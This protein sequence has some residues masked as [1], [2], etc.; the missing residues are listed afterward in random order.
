MANTNW[1]A[2]RI[3]DQ[4]GRVIVI[5]GSTSGIGKETARVLVKKNATVI[6]AVR[7]VKKGEAVADEIRQA[8]PAADVSV[9][10]L[11]LACLESVRAFAASISRDY[12]RLD[13]LIN[14]AG[15]MMCP[16]ARLRMVLRSR[17]APTI[18]AISL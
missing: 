14:N 3:A 17:W 6:L 18:L 5:T 11:D 16:Y 8:Y 1:D 12:D 2:S 15:I 9:R 13:V 4:K 7:N 10:E